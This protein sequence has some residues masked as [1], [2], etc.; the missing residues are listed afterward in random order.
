[1]TRYQNPDPLAGKTTGE[2]RKIV[3]SL[4][5]KPKR[6]PSRAELIEQAKIRIAAR[7]L[8]EER[9]RE[10][11]R[12]EM[13]EEVRNDPLLQGLKDARIQ[14]HVT[15]GATRALLRSGQVGWQDGAVVPGPG[16]DASS[17]Q[18]PAQAALADFARSDPARMA[19]RAHAEWPAWS[20]LGDGS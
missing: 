15:E 14:A 6:K 2:L 8:A 13:H 4:T 20:D 5:P 12:L 1:M 19:D 17:P 16:Q 9:L 10:Q 3:N 11:Q 7:D 18:S